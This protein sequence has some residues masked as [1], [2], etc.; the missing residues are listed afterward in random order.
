MITVSH[1]HIQPPEMFR[2]EVRAKMAASEEEF[3]RIAELAASPARLLEYLD[4]AGVDRAVLIGCVA[5][6]VMGTGPEINPWLAQYAKADPRRLLWAGSVN[7]R[8]SE[9]VKSDLRGVLAMGARLIKIHP[10]HQL[11][12]ANDYVNGG[13]VGEGLAAIYRICEAE[14]VPVMVH[15]GTSIFAGARNKFA[16][17]MP[18]DDVA[19]DFPKLKLIMA[20]G[21]RPLYM[22]T[23]F[24]LLRR[25]ANLYLDISSI[26]PKRL[27]EYFPRLEEVAQKSL[28]GSDWA[29]PGIRGIAGNI[30]DFRALALSESAK[31]RILSGT[32]LE[33][34]PA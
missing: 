10:P 28:F 22:E 14:S 17:P 15:T 33:V 25:H 29:G 34:W 16:D 21:G 19:V 18:L 20:H 2:A 30:A 3:A 32:A 31:Q 4:A 9:N 13:R 12:A 6:E 7:P 24:F 27:L 23:A 1:V 5:P 11:F 8:H 26:P